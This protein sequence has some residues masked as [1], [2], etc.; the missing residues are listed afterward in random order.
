M[1]FIF[2]HTNHLKKKKTDKTE[3]WLSGHFQMQLN[4]ISPLNAE[5][6]NPGKTETNF[7]FQNF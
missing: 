4:G 6:R 2:F 1:G 5:T 3:L 7:E